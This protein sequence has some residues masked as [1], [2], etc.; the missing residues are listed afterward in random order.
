MKVRPRAT[1][2]AGHIFVADPGHRD[3]DTRR[4]RV[5]GIIDFGDWRPGAPV[6]DLAVLRIHGPQLELSA[7]PDGYGAATDETFRRRLDLHTLNQALAALAFS[8]AESDRA[9]VESSTQLVR[10]LITTL[11]G[12]CR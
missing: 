11:D 4:V 7:L 6:H 5:T 9:G 3:G 10:T 1:P 2:P 8:V 12:P